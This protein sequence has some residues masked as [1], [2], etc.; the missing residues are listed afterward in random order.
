ME[1]IFFKQLGLET[2]IALD[3]ETTGLD[4]NLDKIIEI[5]AV[6]FKNGIEVSTFS[7][8]INPQRKI[9]KFIEGL[10]GIKNSDVI[11]K[12]IFNQIINDYN[13]PAKSWLIPFRN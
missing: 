9:P 8:L 6:K 3:I 1:N 5:S 7:K 4:K 2:F 12:P 13:K 11:D 10:T